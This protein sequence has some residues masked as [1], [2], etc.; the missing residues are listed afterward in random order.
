[1]K[2]ILSF[3]VIILC[4]LLLLPLAKLKASDNTIEVISPTTPLKTDAFRI[5]N[6][7]TNYN[8]TML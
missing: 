8:E 7:E 2:K 6:T 5:Y 1:M 3:T 4:A